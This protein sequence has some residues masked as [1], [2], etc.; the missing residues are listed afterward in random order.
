MKILQVGSSLES[1]GG[2]ERY[3]AYLSEG[4]AGRGHDVVVTCAP[5]CPLDMHLSVRSVPIT[6][7]RKFDFPA[8]SQYLRHFKAVRYDVVHVHFSPDFLL[9][10]IA[11]RMTKQP[12]S[13]MSR[14]V[15]LPW[16]QTKVRLYSGL[17]DHFIPVSESVE[18]QLLASGVR[19]EKMTV[20]KAGCPALAPTKI[21]EVTRHE[22]GIHNGVM[23][24]GY[25][26]RLVAE[27][28]VDTLIAACAEL[29][30]GISFEVFGNGPLSSEL[31]SRAKLS[32]S[33]VRFHG[34]RED[35]PECIQAMEAVVI[36]SIWEEAFPYAAL[37]AM[38]V[39]RP[40]IASRVGGM[41]EII[42]HGK[43]G[44]LF[45]KGDFAGLAAATAQ[46]A[47]NPELKAA[48]GAQARETH[49]SCYTIEKMAERIEAV[50]LAVGPVRN[51]TR[52]H[53]PIPR[54]QPD[55]DDL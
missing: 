11:A 33:Q 18:R 36:P 3:V 38:S 49:R 41:P 10:A 52:G 55:G 20:A 35:V 53:E 45:D 50:Y 17:F 19:K 47:C 28:G 51:R 22:L 6:V 5:C 42:E 40:V 32:N 30:K 25:F 46:L 54:L 21:R 23:A 26:G 4:L 1:W 8:F 14:H 37:E 16:T 13:I 24:V 29:P 43:T 12:L 7:R 2:I 9:P 48:M 27:K 39:G 44:L 15:V 31:E 34:F